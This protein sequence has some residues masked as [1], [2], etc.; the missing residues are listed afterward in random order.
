VDSG[1]AFGVQS[2]IVTAPYESMVRATWP[3]ALKVIDPGGIDL[4]LLHQWRSHRPDGL[5]VLRGYFPD[6]HLDPSKV[7]R[8]LRTAET[9]RS[10]SPIVEVPV[11]EAHQSGPDLDALAAYSEVALKRI[12]DAGFR[13]AVGVFSEG[14]PA[15]DDWARLFDLLEATR[16]A[17]GYLALHEYFTPG[18]YL[19]GAHSLRYRAVYRILPDS[20]RVP[21]LI[22]ECGIDGGID[23]PD[24]HR[25]ETGWRGYVDAPRYADLLTGYR[26]S[27]AQ[28]DYV[29]GAFVFVCGS[30]D[31]WRLFD[32]GDEVDLRHV[33]TG[34]CEGPPRWSPSPATPPAPT[35]APKETSVRAGLFYRMDSDVP[36]NTVPEMIALCASGGFDAVSPKGADGDEWEGDFD[37]G[38]LALTSVEKLVAER[39]A[40]AAAGI[41]LIPWVVYRG[42]LPLAEAALHAAIANACG[43]VIVDFEWG[44]RG[45]VD[46]GDW[47]DALAYFR[48][49]RALAPGARIRF[50]PDPRQ[51]VGP[52]YD[53][54]ALAPMVDV[55]MGQCY[56]TDFQTTWENALSVGFNLDA[57]MRTTLPQEPVLPGDARTVDIAAAA[58]YLVARGA[59]VWVFQRTGL[60]GADFAAIKAALAS[61]P[62]PPPE[63]EPVDPVTDALNNLWDLTL[64]PGVGSEERRAS[65]QAA[66]GTLKHALGL[67]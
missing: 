50:C 54:A 41:A 11:N 18:A 8:V 39:D 45:F 15:L 9:L 3:R 55:V 13:P 59:P 23:A 60:V 66:I 16:R 52:N 46:H 62:P 65:A 36:E 4:D 7:D 10:L 67:Q 24:G 30:T 28:D 42:I 5:L 37:V 21:L 34:S 43:E 35:P 17:D 40:Y 6:E 63:P 33:F 61:A 22:T 32:V 19:D 47:H 1:L 48:E 14:N 12:R 57:A 31:Q 51:V 38:E 53:A 64:Q 56:W 29:H 20:C 2:Q 44:Y 49:L 26:N 27:L 25:P 58:E